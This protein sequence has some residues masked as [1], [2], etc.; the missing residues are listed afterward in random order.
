MIPIPA[1]P[2]SAG[3]LKAAGLALCVASVLAMG[4]WGGYRWQAG[5]VAEAEKARDK[6]RD[7]RDRW[8]HNAESY[9]M[10]IEQQKEANAKALEAAADQERKAKKAIADAKAQK[11]RYERKLA[12]IGAGIEKDK[13][14]PTC[15]T[16]L[17]K[18]VCGAPW[19]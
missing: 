9:S 14:D 10:A 1:L 3:T 11:D 19:E 17:E 18:P 16:E 12:E 7:E 8:Q 13:L 6:A 5:N 2:I 4:F 15:K